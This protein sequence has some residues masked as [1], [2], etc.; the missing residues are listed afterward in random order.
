MAERKRVR[1][2]Q[3]KVGVLGIT[4]FVIIF[5]LVF[6]LTSSKGIFRSYAILR[7]YMEDAAGMTKGTSV[8]LNGIEIGYLDAVTLTGSRD[9]K[10]AVEFTMKVRP[11]FLS[12]IP[13][14]SIAGVTAAN[15]LGD[16]FIDIIRGQSTQMVK[17]GSELKAQSGQDIPELMAQ[18]ANLLQSF[19]Q[20]VNRVDGLLAGIDAGKGNIG[21]LL[22]DRELYDRAN[23]I[24]SE[25]QKLL[26]DVRTGN[27]SLSK[28]LYSDQLY[29]DIRSPINRVDSILAGVQAGQ[30][31]AGRLLKDPALFDEMQK[32]LADMH[33]M[34]AELNA[35]KGTAGQLLKNDQIAKQLEALAVKLNAT[36]E[37]LNSGQ[38]TIG[39][40]MVNPALYDALTGTTREFQT[41]AKEF[42]ANP[43]KFLTI[44]LTL[45]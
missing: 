34:V 27:G 14:D 37:R 7:T 29:N 39:Q 23:A 36:M 28:V 9:P 15:L 11:S 43:K 10:R 38:G 24:V 21:L 13:V 20:I 44:R 19:Q 12:K 35:G 4:A 40:L 5:V 2:S 41:M 6:L 1:W 17:D 31:S 18:S 22:K 33:T 26:N 8:R 45:F 16:K 30:G 32:T 42:R 3:L 25:G